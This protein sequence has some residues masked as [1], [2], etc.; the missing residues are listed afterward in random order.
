MTAVP[1]TSSASYGSETEPESRI[2]MR[3]LEQITRLRRSSAHEKVPPHLALAG[4]REILMSHIQ[5]VLGPVEE[6]DCQQGLSLFIATLQDP[7]LIRMS[8]EWYIGQNSCP[9]SSYFCRSAIN[10]LRRF[11]LCNL[12]QALAAP[13]IQKLK[14]LGAFAICRELRAAAADSFQRE[15]ADIAKIRSRYVAAAKRKDALHGPELIA[16]RTDELARYFIARGRSVATMQVDAAGTILSDLLSVK[17]ERSY[18]SRVDPLH[19]LL[20]PPMQGPSLQEILRHPSYYSS[21]ELS[22][23]TPWSESTATPKTLKKEYQPMGLFVPDSCTHGASCSEACLPL[24]KKANQLLHKLAWKRHQ[25]N[26]FGAI[27]LLAIRPED[28]AHLLYRSHDDG[29]QCDEAK[30]SPQLSQATSC[31]HGKVRW[32]ILAH[33]LPIERRLRLLRITCLL[34][35]QEEQDLHHLAEILAALRMYGRSLG[36]KTPAQQNHLATSLCERLDRL[37]I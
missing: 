31:R 11:H 25:N 27:Y 3:V 35:K 21:T 36:S 18:P 1:P 26:P 37:E 28:A 10:R 32:R 22:S 6:R 23:W 7:T 19:M 24:Q 29:K 4:L 5:P 34:P 2:A 12:D 17:R 14:Q 8:V 16:Q 15:R 13:L 20:Q 30:R 9:P 33:R